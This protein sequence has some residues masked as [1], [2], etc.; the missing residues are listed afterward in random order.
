MNCNELATGR[1][2]YAANRKDDSFAIFLAAP[3]DGQLKLLGHYSHKGVNTHTR[4]MQII[5]GAPR[6]DGGP[7]ARHLVV[8]HQDSDTLAVY[9][10]DVAS[11]MVRP[12]HSQADPCIAFRDS[13][14][15]T[16]LCLV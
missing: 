13:L 2:V 11:G 8:A 9:A 14:S 10:L 5:E 16:L 7:L 4:N 6:R 3:D 1:F 12:Q 15:L